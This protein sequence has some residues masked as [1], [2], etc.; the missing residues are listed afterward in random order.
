VQVATV[1]AD[2]KVVLNQVVIARDHGN[3]VELLSGISATDRVIENPPDGIM[4]GDVVHVATV[5][6]KH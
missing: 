6:A 3:R 2:N 1:G 5:E 4:Q